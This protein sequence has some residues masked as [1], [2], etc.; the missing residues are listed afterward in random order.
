MAAQTPGTFK[1]KAMINALTG[2]MCVTLPVFDR[3]RPM[4]GT[5]AARVSI[6]HAEVVHALAM[7]DALIHL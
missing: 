2:I 1:M 7:V 4:K 5:K 3:Q 6:A